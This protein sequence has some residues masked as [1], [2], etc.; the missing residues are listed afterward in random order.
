MNPTNDHNV[1]ILGAGF[2]VEAGLPVVFNFLETMREAHPWLVA[3]GRKREARAI[4]EVLKFRLESAAAAYWIQMDLENIEELFSLASAY[5]AQMGQHVR[6]AIAGT[7]DFAAKTAPVRKTEIELS[8]EGLSIMGNWC[9]EHPSEP[10]RKLIENYRLYLARLLG[11]LVDGEPRGKNTFITF[12]YDTILEDSLSALKVPFSYRF[13]SGEVTFLPGAP[14]SDD[15]CEVSVLKVHGSINWSWMDDRTTHVF[16]SYSTLRARKLTP[17]LIPPTWKKAYQKQFS[18]VMEQA[19]RL[20]ESAT[21]VVVVGF[22]MPQTDV[23]F[24]YL[25]AAGF[26]KNISLRKI[27]FVNPRADELKAR[28]RTHFK[29][30]YIEDQRVDFVPLK[31]SEM[32]NEYQFLANVGRPGAKRS[33]YTMFG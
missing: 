14:G 32:A 3:R 11:M 21:R 4:T 2:S 10:K 15:K 28:A 33:L 25:L 31:L 17:Q 26:A 12:N 7:L 5:P 1:Y 24:K 27:V 23:H 22:S 8:T 20:L 29:P 6:L 30:E 13:A 18:T 19:A 9:D 16:P